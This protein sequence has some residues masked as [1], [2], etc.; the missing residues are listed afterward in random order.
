MSSIQHHTKIIPTKEELK[1][2][3]EK[4]DSIK[5]IPIATIQSHSIQ[6]QTKTFSQETPTANS[7]NVYG[8]YKKD[9]NVII[10]QLNQKVNELQSIL[11]K[12]SYK[13]N[14]YDKINQEN[15]ELKQKYN[16]KNT[17]SIT[18]NNN[19]NHNNN[20]IPEDYFNPDNIN[21]NNPTSSINNNNIDGDIFNGNINNNSQNSNIHLLLT[22]LS[23]LKAENISL[24][25]Q[26]STL[27]NQLFHFEQ[28]KTLTQYTNT[29]TNLSNSDYIKL[30]I[31]SLLNKHKV[32]D[33]CKNTL[34]SLFKT[35]PNQNLLSFLFNRIDNLEY[36]NYYLTN[37]IEHYLNMILQSADEVCEYINV[38]GDIRSVLNLVPD[39]SK[40][41]DDFFIIRD[42]LNKKESTLALQKE[43]M[44]ERKTQI[45]Q[46][47]LLYKNMNVILCKDKVYDMKDK[48]INILN[49]K[50]NEMEIMKNE[51]TKYED[52]ILYLQSDK[53][54]NNED[55][56][57]N[58]NELIM[59]NGLL[60]E[61]NMKLRNVIV[62]LLANV[63]GDIVGKDVM[64]KV[65][66]VVNQVSVNGEMYGDVIDLL[67]T[68][69]MFME[70]LLGVGVYN[71]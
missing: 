71:E 4:F 33:S 61:N 39:N 36:Q 18:S 40:L 9:A 35:I 64:D 56:F 3:R 70:H 42:T 2:L 51:M 55:L 58:K 34:L 53:G 67:K 8:S 43:K 14:N 15:I 52:Y 54:C 47:D 65:F 20:I 22:N 24:K 16:K 59:F 10:N 32:D 11:S 38:I 26:I 25:E 60:K 44:L 29:E 57:R 62:E 50:I 13:I 27:S 49:E 21:I 48:C 30:S 28:E 37:K 68:Q 7:I 23:K 66:Q 5:D 41:S 6:H 12:N 46:N 17:I 1:L 63:N 19:N 31:L 69:A 45:S